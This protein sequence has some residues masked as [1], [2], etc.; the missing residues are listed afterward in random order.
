MHPKPT[1]RLP[2]LS[3]GVDRALNAAAASVL[4]GPGAEAARADCRKLRGL[5]RDICYK[6]LA[7]NGAKP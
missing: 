5:A 6:A 3:P 4:D 1:L 7:L 2:V